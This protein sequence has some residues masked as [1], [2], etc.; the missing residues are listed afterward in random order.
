VTITEAARENGAPARHPS[1]S[2]GWRLNVL[3]PVELCYDGRPVEVTGVARTILVLLAR[4]AGE[5]VTTTSLIAAIWGSAPPEDPGNVIAS[6]I[7]RLRKALTAIAPAVNPTQVIVT[8]PSGYILDVTSPNV[9]VAAFERLVA[10][11]R[12]ALEV[13]QPTLARQRLDEAL[14]LWRGA[15]YED[16]LDV[17]RAEAGRLEDLRLAAVEHRVE[18]RLALSTPTADEDLVSELERLTE[19]HWHR[20]RL[21]AQ[22]MIALF[23]LGRRGDALAAH[24]RAQVLLAEGLHAEPGPELR[25]AERAV[26]ANDLSLYGSPPN[27]STVPDELAG[28]APAC[29]G[30]DEELA[31]LESALDLAATR[32]AQPRLIVG[33]PGMGKTRMLAELAHRAAA[34]GIVVRYYRAH[35]GS[36]IA[37]PDRLSLLLID[38]ADLASPADRETIT[39]FVRSTLRHPVVTILTCRDPVRVG[40]LAGLPKLVMSGLDDASVA[41]IV[42]VYAP[43]VADATA[44]AAMVNAG[45]VPARIHRAASEWAF[46]RAGRRIDR[47]VESAAEPTRWLQS[48]RDEVVGG[49]RELAHVR[50]QARLLR[51][52]VRRV[53]DPYRGIGPLQSD[54]A[55]LFHGR[56]RE[57]AE[58]IAHLVRAPLVAVVGEPGVGKS[59]L[60]RAGLLP[61]LASGV[62]PGSARWRQIV[63]T[64]ATVGSLA[65]ILAAPPPDPADP[66]PAD[67]ADPALDPA[68][69]DPAPAPAPEA[70]DPEQAPSIV[71]G[72]SPVG[73]GDTEAP[74]SG[75]PAT[76][77][78]VVDQ[79]EE[80]FTVLDDGVRARFLADLVDALTDRTRVVLTL[81]SQRYG[82]VADHPDLS[83]MVTA[84]TFLLGSMSAD[85]LRR[86]VE[87]PALAAQMSFEDGLVETIVA[88]A[89]ARPDLVPLAAALRLLA[90]LGL[91]LASYRQIGGLAGVLETIGERALT[92]VDDRSAAER[93]L[94]RLATGGARTQARA[95]EVGAAHTL[96]AHGVLTAH[97]DGTV[98]MARDAFLRHWPRL[99]RLADDQRAE[100]DLRDHLSRAAPAWSSGQAEVYRGARLIA[101]L[102]FGTDHAKEL[103]QAEH[104]FLAAGRRQLLVEENRR[105]RKVALLHRW[106]LALV[107][108][109]VAAV[110]I[111][112]L[113]VVKQ[114]ATAADG[115]RADARRVGALATGEPDLRLAMLMAVAANRLDPAT[116]EPL[117]TTLGRSPDLIA[118]AGDGVTAV[119]VSPD[120]TTVAVGSGDGTIRLLDASTLRE[121]GTRWEYPGQGPVG[122]LAFTPDGR[123]LVSWGGAGDGAGIVVWDVG[124]GRMDGAPFGQASP[125][126]GGLLADGV[127]LLVGQARRAV[128]WSI[129]ARTPSTAYELPVDRV[130]ALAVSP[131][132]RLV[133]FG[134]DDGT[135][136]FEPRTGDVTR[137]PDARRPSSI[138]PDGRTL[139]TVRGD[140]IE[141]WGIG[142]RER[143]GEARH[144]TGDVV[145][146]AWSPDGSAFASAG[147]DG[148]VVVWDVAD[149][150]PR[151]RH[152]FTGHAGP[153]RAVAFAPDGRA[154]VSVGQEGA[155]LLWDLHGT[156]GLGPR[157][158]TGDRRALAC[159]VAGRDMTPEEWRRVLPDRPYQHVCPM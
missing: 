114:T 151:A 74:A 29:L 131:D 80:A 85:D 102:D 44:V 14:A 36:L 38:D 46:G 32:R 155:A 99:R 159:A 96:T 145:A 94:G 43:A 24:R 116:T 33:S 82:V 143:R 100:R 136:V 2:S 111:A 65:E 126:A 76:T 91:T 1:H 70:V 21:W 142:S 3:G 107:L 86:A 139:L 52:D 72:P 6:Q 17:A 157:A 132:G 134:T 108:A 75:E 83:R 54:D 122:G 19:V 90:T 28:P 149:A 8:V 127:T 115:L 109:L 71:D 68:P 158:E 77:L 26:L 56:E 57:T 55:E 59:S 154:V 34:R 118:A 13:G 150:R 60:V 51:P 62:L 45:G 105:R 87:Q 37:D 78:L 27:P 88:D 112:A 12:R 18:A 63:V 140:V 93:L 156:R 23:R 53:V 104:D 119:A 40:D 47:A 58:L 89:R 20:E 148:L 35:A 49:V 50:A 147:A 9:D 137:L 30:R 135:T 124:A 128:A 152:V 79:F 113:A 67:P 95:D 125:T 7:S 92:A 110:A 22:L 31:W 120:G 146:T 61:A 25:S 123:R 4:N 97:D 15:A 130:D 48:I 141:V 5:E 39:T 11:G 73:P 133:A 98:E 129:E 117:A 121:R 84:N 42:R 10:D 153:A 106:I 144:H 41:G 66:D 138:S 103:T 69:P 64:P 101:A 16:V 81:R